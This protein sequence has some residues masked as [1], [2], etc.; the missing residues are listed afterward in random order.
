MDLRIGSRVKIET[1]DDAAREYKLSDITG[2]II[3]QTECPDET[4]EHKVRWDDG[5]I[6]TPEDL[7]CVTP[8]HYVNI[9][10]H[11]RAYGGREE[12]G[13]WYDTYEPEE[14]ECKWFATTE[15]AE[16]HVATA[17]AWCDD[18]NS[19]RRSDLSSVISEGRYEVVLEAWPAEYSPSSRP[20]Y[21]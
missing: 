9:Y 3:S 1:W 5:S 2:T 15:E 17:Q 11:D 14:S 13:W 8:K 21:C 20:Y 4:W 10:L 19:Q 18:E 16:S 12:G 7:V 6:S